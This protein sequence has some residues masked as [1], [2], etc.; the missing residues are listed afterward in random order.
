MKNLLLFLAVCLLFSSCLPM[1]VVRLEPEAEV[2]TYRYGEKIVVAESTTARVE[3]SYYDASPKFIVFNMEVENTGT[4]AF[5]FDSGACTLVPDVGPVRSAIDPEMQLLSMDLNSVKEARKAEIIGWAGAGLAIVSTVAAYVD[6][7]SATDAG[8]SIG[9]LLASD[10]LFNT[11]NLAF[12]LI[13]FSANSTENV[14]RNAIPLQGEMPLPS[15]R[16]FWLDHAV[17]LTTVKPGQRIVGKVAFE[18]NDQASNFSFNVTV[19]G[20]EFQFPFSQRLFK[21]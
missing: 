14:Q 13:D 17:R 10:A 18:R 3:V 1:Q 11:T 9:T 12:T 15:N 8:S 2:D 19:A 6:L 5:N 7:G 4:E 16:F 20:E 21:P